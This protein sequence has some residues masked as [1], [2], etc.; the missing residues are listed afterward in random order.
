MNYLFLQIKVQLFLKRK[1]IKKIKKII[2]KNIKNKKKFIMKKIMI[3]FKILI[4]VL[5]QNKKVYLKKK[6]NHYHL[7]FMIHQFLR[8]FRLIY[9]LYQLVKYRLKTHRVMKIKILTILMRNIKCY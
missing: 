3:K 9:N 4:I 1:K 2:K 5:F 6:I 7:K 8:Q